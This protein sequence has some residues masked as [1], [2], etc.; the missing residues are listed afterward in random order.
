MTIIYTITKTQARNDGHGYPATT[1][2]FTT[3]SKEVADIQFKSV[4]SR[5]EPHHILKDVFIESTNDEV[6]SIYRL[7]E[8]VL[9]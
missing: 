4:T 9:E 5:A 8:G 2:L 1:I 7:H 6:T 3:T